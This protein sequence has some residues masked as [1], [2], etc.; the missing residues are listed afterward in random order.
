MSRS[1]RVISLGWV[2]PRSQ[3]AERVAAFYGE[4]LQLPLLRGYADAWLF[5]AGETVVFEP[6]SDAGPEWRYPD[7]KSSPTLPVIRCVEL[8]SVLSR[9]RRF[10]VDVVASGNDE[11]GDYAVFQDIDE[12]FVMLRQAPMDSTRPI[13]IVARERLTMRENHRAYN[14]GVA[15]LPRDIQGIDS[16]IRHVADLGAMAAFYSDTVGLP[17]VEA[18]PTHV[19][20][21]CGD[22]TAL[23]LRAGGQAESPPQDRFEVPDAFILRVD[24]FDGFRET[25][26]A[27]KVRIVNDRIQFGRGVLGYICD[28]EGHLIGYEERYEQSG[29]RDNAVAFAEDM[30]AN[31]RWRERSR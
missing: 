21:D 16:I 31:R 25:L 20:L 3:N 23:E 27:N 28:P 15:P 19:V 1:A 2:L 5:W 22:S 10:N 12:H 24:D 14:P 8:G 9:L 17:I 6:K 7:W 26:L 13:D 4:V 30:E 11:F 29:C 18:A